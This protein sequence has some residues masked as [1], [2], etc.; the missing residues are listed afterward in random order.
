MR[1]TRGEESVRM[2]QFIIIINYER[3]EGKREVLNWPVHYY[4]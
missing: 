1:E 4:Y 2:T 3:D